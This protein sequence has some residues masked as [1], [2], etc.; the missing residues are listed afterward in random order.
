MEKTT[1]ESFQTT[2]GDSRTIYWATVTSGANSGSGYVPGGISF[3][4]RE[5]SRSRNASERSV[6]S[7]ISQNDWVTGRSTRWDQTA[8]NSKTCIG[9][10]NIR[11]ICS[12][13]TIVRRGKLDIPKSG[14]MESK[15]VVYA[16]FQFTLYKD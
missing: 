1:H 11:E 5:K 13:Y 9:K 7:I 14:G 6:D 4:S 10:C 15:N 2:E 3:F 8:L 16:L 12:P